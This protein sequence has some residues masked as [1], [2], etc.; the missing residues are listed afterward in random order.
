MTTFDF[1]SS[2]VAEPEAYG[3]ANTP[4][5][6][7][8]IAAELPA[9]PAAEV[10]PPVGIDLQQ[11]SFYVDPDSLKMP[12]YNQMDNDFLLDVTVK[13]SGP[14]AK[15]MCVTKRIK[16]CKETLL[17]EAAFKDGYMTATATYVESVQEA[18]ESTD[19][20]HSTQRMLELAG[21]N[22]P[23]NYVR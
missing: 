3:Y 6:A 13:I 23:K 16:F 17:K 15:T 21:I 12:S 1:T 8:P 7:T 14:L 5:E 20:K 19:G 22:H 10:N 9:E 2:Q 18:Q 11:Y 4:V